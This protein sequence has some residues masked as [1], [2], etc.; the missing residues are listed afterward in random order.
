VCSGQVEELSVRGK[1]AV[2]QKKILND[3]NVSLGEANINDAEDEYLQL[4]AQIDKITLKLFNETIKTSKVERA[5]SLVDRLHLEKSFDIAIQISDRMG[6]R[7]LSDLI[8]EVKIQ[9][10]PPVDEDFFDD[11]NS[12]GSR[13][14]S[15]N[16]DEA[17][18]LERQERGIRGISPEIGT[19]KA[20][21]P[22]DDASESTHDESPPN[23]SLKRKFEDNAA[24]STKRRNPFA[25]VG[26]QLSLIFA[27]CLEHF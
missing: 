21:T 12:L 26:I 22:R 17:M 25:K 20:R 8:D 15:D 14:R 4:S 1:I 9:R 24:V 27:F 11:N 7:K 16:Y 18:T 13:E 3:Y 10:F 2:E 19:P 5:L 23:A 6:H